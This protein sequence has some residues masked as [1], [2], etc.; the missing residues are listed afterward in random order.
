[1]NREEIGRA[2]KLVAKIE[3]AEDILEAISDPE[4]CGL[5]R[6]D[7]EAVCNIGNTRRMF[8]GLEDEEFENCVR[9]AVIRIKSRAETEL[10]QI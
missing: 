8:I 2:N 7:I 10:K 5:I 6:L 1:M 4:K 3:Q 9:E